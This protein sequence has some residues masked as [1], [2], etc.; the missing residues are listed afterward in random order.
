MLPVEVRLVGEGNPCVTNRKVGDFTLRL[1]PELKAG[2]PI[3]ISATLKGYR[4]WKPIN[5]K[6]RIP[7]DLDKEIIE[8]LLL[9]E[10]SPKFE[11]DEYIE[12]MV[13]RG[14]LGTLDWEGKP[15]ATDRVVPDKLKKSI[16]QWEKK[17]EQR[18]NQERRVAQAALAR[19]DWK[20]AAD[21]ADR[22]A[23]REIDKPEGMRR[24]EA[25]AKS[26][27]VKGDALLGS[28]ELE[29]AL[30]A[31][32]EGLNHA[33]RDENPTIWAELMGRIGATNK[34]LGERANGD[35]R[36]Q[37]I[38]NAILAFRAALEVYTRRSTPY[39]WAR[40]QNELGL[41]SKAL[42][43]EETEESVRRKLTEESIDAFRESLNVYTKS[44]SPQQ[45]ARTQNNLGNALVSLGEICAEHM[46]E[47]SR[48]WFKDAVTAHRE[49]LQVYSP[50]K[51]FT[52]EHAWTQSKLGIALRNLGDTEN[53]AEGMIRLREAV[54]LI[55]S[56]IR[57]YTTSEAMHAE[58]AEAQ[59]NLGCA[60]GT[61]GR[62]QPE[63]TKRRKTL[64]S[65]IDA[66]RSALD[67]F[68]R[69][70]STHHFAKTQNSIGEIY[71]HA[72]LTSKHVDEQ[73]SMLNEAVK[74]YQVAL[75]VISLETSPKDWTKIRRNMGVALMDL[76]VRTGSR[77]GRRMLE[78][79]VGALQEVLDS[80]KQEESPWRWAD[81]QHNLGKVL[82]ET[83][84]IDRGEDGQI[85][86]EEAV[87]AYRAALTVY[88]REITPN[89]WATVTID[90]AQGLTALGEIE[91][92]D[93]GVELLREA[94][95]THQDALKALTRTSHPLLRAKAHNSMGVAL[96]ALG[97]LE[98]G[99]T[100]RT[101]LM[102]AV[103]AHR[104]ALTIYTQE[105]QP[106]EW[107]E[108]QKNL[109]LAL[110]SL[111]A[112]DIHQLGHQ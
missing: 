68:G 33:R 97:R 93:D 96:Q 87:D 27:V 108:T 81:V 30:V 109:G 79:A 35:A 74:A 52:Q 9:P 17:A 22:A 67:L 71:H 58:L 56:A 31:Y 5:G 14:G 65:A 69:K 10:N 75:S 18:K 24:R 101:N 62:R 92:G 23:Q 16:E 78:A 8:I 82:Q 12:H 48:Q 73:R 95:D 36:K 57:I 6:E 72:A 51:N 63:E 11:D 103:D 38:A 47:D 54:D 29:R 110:K 64:E 26:R 42:G 86:L 100:G 39:E 46:E 77:D 80:I 107:A 104:T 1:P 88:T 84:H 59:F 60:L 13:E 21:Y 98:G 106:H 112:P 66:Y 43:E 25:L 20:K 105:A 28:N 19:G 4:I 89:Q 34:A 61:L 94:V 102:R 85:R 2:D 7:S 40:I 70:S 15:T 99:P 3:T 90:L 49:A 50:Q 111:A 76:G 37:H 32:E 44:A 53:A 45:W 55:Q 91:G 83:G 41:A